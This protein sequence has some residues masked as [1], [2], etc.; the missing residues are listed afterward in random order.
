MT[1]VCHLVLRSSFYA[2]P[3]HMLSSIDYVFMDF[4]AIMAVQ[5][6]MADLYVLTRFLG[7]VS[8]SR[9]CLTF[10]AHRCWDLVLPWYIELPLAWLDLG[11]QVAMCMAI[12]SSNVLRLL[13]VYG[14]S[15]L[16]DTLSDTMITGISRLTCTLVP[17]LICSFLKLSGYHP[18]TYQQ[19][20]YDDLTMIPP[21][22]SFEVCSFFTT[23]F[24][25]LAL[26]CLGLIQMERSKLRQDTRAVFQ[27][28]LLCL[29]S[30]TVYVSF[31]AFLYHQLTV[32]N[33]LEKIKLSCL[34]MLMGAV[35]CPLLYLL[36]N[37]WH[38]YFIFKSYI[39][40]LRFRI[41]SLFYRNVVVPSL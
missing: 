27:S 9:Q 25:V 33:T 24:M 30:S 14:F 23:P 32:V 13:Y 2:K 35:C 20:F 18:W 19:F 41:Q 37:D 1:N 15:H 17:T 6:S 4:A 38:S 5:A 11:L 22:T 34:V 10:N 39:L 36:K 26:I 12:S 31:L 21:N 8:C 3:L 40:P 29:F 7:K 16:L 28:F